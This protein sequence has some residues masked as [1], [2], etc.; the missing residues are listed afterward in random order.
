MVEQTVDTVVE[1]DQLCDVTLVVVAG[2]ETATDVLVVVIVQSSKLDDG[3][4]CFEVGGCC[5]AASSS[6]NSLGKG[7][8]FFGSAQVLLMDFLTG[9]VDDSVLF[10]VILS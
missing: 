3:L 6:R 2:V 1:V 8:F 10:R 7:R 4:D 9:G 5:S